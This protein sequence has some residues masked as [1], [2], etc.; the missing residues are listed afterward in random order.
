MGRVALSSSQYF[1]VLTERTEDRLISAASCC[2]DWWKARDRQVPAKVNCHH[3]GDI[4]HRNSD[5]MM[6]L[7]E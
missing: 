7:G 3:G 4:R 5:M 2:S 6:S 1:E